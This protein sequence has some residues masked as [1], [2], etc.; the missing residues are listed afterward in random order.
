V[1]RRWVIVL[2]SLFVTATTAS[3][4]LASTSKTVAPTASEFADVFI[5]AANLYAKEHSDPARL[6][7]ADCVQAAPGRYMCSYA[8]TRPGAIT[9][10]HLMQARWTPW[11]ARSFT[12]TLSG[13]SGRCGS[14]REALESLK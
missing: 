13:R 2:A 8:T 5:G 4:S 14:L 10:C 6:R 7:H 11:R 3:A 9:E 1:H 12:V